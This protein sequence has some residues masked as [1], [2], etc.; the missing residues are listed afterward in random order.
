MGVV[1]GIG[2]GLDETSV[3][4]RERIRSEARPDG[5]PRYTPL[6]GASLMVF[7]A[8]AFQCLSTLAVLRRE[9]GGWRL[10]ALI[11]AYMTALAWISSFA[12]YQGGRWL[13]FT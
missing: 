12:V 1:Y 2:D 6:V 13:G 9:T 11:V 10:P 5:S 8:L 4:L 7:F 3:D